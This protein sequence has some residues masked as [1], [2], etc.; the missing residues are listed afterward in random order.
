MGEAP[1]DWPQSGKLLPLLDLESSVREPLSN[2]VKAVAPGHVSQNCGLN[3][4]E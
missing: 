1:T 4:E 3:I 2:P